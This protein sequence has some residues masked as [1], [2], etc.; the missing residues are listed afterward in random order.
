M[1]TPEPS[2]E[3]LL[4]ARA[5]RVVTL[6]CETDEPD[7]RAAGQVVAAGDD[8][9]VR[10]QGAFDG[11]CGLD[12]EYIVR[13][14]LD[15][16]PLPVRPLLVDSPQD[17]ARRGGASWLGLP[18]G[19][20]RQIPYDAGATR[21]PGNVLWQGPGPRLEEIGPGPD[22]DASWL[23]TIPGQ[24]APGD[25]ILSIGYRGCS[26]VGSVRVGPSSPASLPVPVS[27]GDGHWIEVPGYGIAMWFCGDAYEATAESRIRVPQYRCDPSRGER[28][29]VIC[30]LDGSGNGHGAWE[31]RYGSA[32]GAHR[33]A[34]GRFVRETYHIDLLPIH[35]PACEALR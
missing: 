24:T 22:G 27:T 12:G 31:L 3:E 6:C 25:H 32:V 18:P 11:R 33:D 10:V 30:A 34:D 16:L 1:P 26:W 14:A 5:W 28:P 17:L 29:T 7:W 20:E 9:L 8:V 19:P 13:I 21:A 35:Y 2:A 23:G 4:E 15:G